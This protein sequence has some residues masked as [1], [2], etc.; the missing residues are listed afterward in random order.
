MYCAMCGVQLLE[1]ALCPHHEAVFNRRWA[2]G[3]K[4]WCDFFHRGIVGAASPWN[5][6]GWDIHSVM[7][8]DDAAPGA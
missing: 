7:E 3:N 6:D 8:V 1:G 5:W 4:A 2:S